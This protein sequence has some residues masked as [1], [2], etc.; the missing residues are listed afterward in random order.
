MVDAFGFVS[1][2]VPLVGYRGPFVGSGN[3]WM[4]RVDGFVGCYGTGGTRNGRARLRYGSEL[5]SYDDRV[6]MPMGV[7]AGWFTL[8][9]VVT[10]RGGGQPPLWS[11]WNP[12]MAGCWE[13]RR[14]VEER[15]RE[16]RSR[17]K[18][19]ERGPARGGG[20]ETEVEVAVMCCT[21][22]LWLAVE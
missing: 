10:Q 18:S 12:K 22:R 16:H 11:L 2:I 7:D 9:S 6:R 3:G 15:K 17:V 4:E 13:S 19:G 21:T 20:G 14:L 1:G 8:S 5:E